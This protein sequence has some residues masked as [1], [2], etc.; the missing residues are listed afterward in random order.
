[1]YIQD[2]SWSNLSVRFLL[3][4][5]ALPTCKRGVGRILREVLGEQF[6]VMCRCAEE[7][8]VRLNVPV[9][10][11][12]ALAVFESTEQLQQHL[13]RQAL[14]Q[15]AVFCTESGKILARILPFKY[16]DVLSG[17]VK[18]L[19]KLDDVG[20]GQS[21]IDPLHQCDLQRHQTLAILQ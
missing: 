2:H 9:K 3:R 14:I 1:M 7:Q 4:T 20:T 12:T 6:G 10:D 13:L 15:M 19:H 11:S 21:C 8:V 16:H 18:P 17:T 5:A